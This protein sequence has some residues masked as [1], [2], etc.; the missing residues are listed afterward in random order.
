M[1]NY[2]IRRLLIAIP[3][4]IPIHSATCPCVHLNG[5][6][7]LHVLAP[8]VPGLQSAY[9]AYWMNIEHPA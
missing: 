5:M 1:G 2:L 8:V 4:V 6:V 7:H 3:S 9:Y